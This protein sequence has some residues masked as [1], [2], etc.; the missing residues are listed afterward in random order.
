MGYSFS[1][2]IRYTEADLN[3]RLSIFA[4][5]NYLQDCSLFQSE[6]VGCG[7]DFLDPRH[8]AWFLSAWN[9]VIDEM[10]RYLEHI[11]I[12][13]WAYAFRGPYGFRNFTI[14]GEDGRGF[15]RADSLWFLFDT[16]KKIPAR[17][18]E[19]YAAPYE[20]QMEKKLEMPKTERKI[21]IPEGSRADLL[22]APTLAVAPHHLDTNLHMN[23]AQ[24]VEAARDAA[25]E[26]FQKKFGGEAPEKKYG[27]L[28]RI[29]AQYKKA[30]VLGDQM[31]P[32]VLFEN[33]GDG[34]GADALPRCYVDLRDPSGESYATIRMTFRK[35]S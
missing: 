34:A 4:M 24:Y 31:C 35:T 20:S 19:A 5:I 22:Q 33:V 26:V 21:F 7:M 3:H 11:V 16:E 13:T 14:R 12:S 2:R 15:I 32:F 10:P 6:D 23:N 1:S 28:Y 25:S 30:A 18:E 17:V 29:E 9:I 8:R 27:S